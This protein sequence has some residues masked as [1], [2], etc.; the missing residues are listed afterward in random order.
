MPR[1]LGYPWA[2]LCPPALAG[3]ERSRVTET[4]CV[5]SSF[6]HKSKVWLC[7][8]LQRKLTLSQPNPGMKKVSWRGGVE[9]VSYF[10]FR[11]VQT[12]RIPETHYFFSFLSHILSNYPAANLREE[13]NKKEQGFATTIAGW[14]NLIWAT[15]GFAFILPGNFCSVI[16]N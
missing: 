2:W 16:R 11:S 9:V 1:G 8:L 15:L 12:F 4:S 10:P 7:Q 13:G 6:Q 5:I 14:P 3:E